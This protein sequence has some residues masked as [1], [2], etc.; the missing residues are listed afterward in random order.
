MGQA[1]WN[2]LRREFAEELKSRGKSRNTIT[3]YASDLG[4]LAQW[5]QE[6]YGQDGAGEPLTSVNSIDLLDQTDGV[7]P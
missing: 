6:T 2:S 4:Q 3:A 1:D 5:H 7:S